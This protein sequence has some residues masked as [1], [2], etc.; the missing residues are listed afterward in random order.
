[1]VDYAQYVFSERESDV[2][3]ILERYRSR[4]LVVDNTDNTMHDFYLKV[5]KATS[6]EE[7]SRYQPAADNARW[8]LLFRNSLLFFD[9]QQGGKDPHPPEHLRLIYE[10]VWTNPL[11][12]IKLIGTYPAMKIYERVA[13]ARVVMGGLTPGNAAELRIPVKTNRERTFLY[14]QEKTADATGHVEWVLPYTSDGIGVA[15]FVNGQKRD[16]WDKALI[17]TDKDVREGRTI[18]Y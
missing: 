2:L 4:Y 15:L 16:R 17:V 18:F 13:G 14:R 11:P 9:G 10:T 3:P 5:L 7:F 12:F 6:P 1:M 8:P